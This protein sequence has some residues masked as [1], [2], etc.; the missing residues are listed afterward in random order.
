MRRKPARRVIAMLLAGATLTGCQLQ[1]RNDERLSFQA[2]ATRDRVTAPVA[3][4]WSMKGFQGV[5]LDGSR[6]PEKGAYAVFVDAAPMP[7]GEDLKWVARS[8]AGCKRDAQCPSKQ[9]L[10][11]HGVYVTFKTSISLPTLPMKPDGVGDEQHYV[12]VVLLDG[13]GRRLRESAWSRT[14][15]TKRRPAA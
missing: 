15:T 7:V 6:S 12:N 13:T 4:S 8:D 10:A 2:P 5:G 3:V 9:Y 11:E 14:F 1:F